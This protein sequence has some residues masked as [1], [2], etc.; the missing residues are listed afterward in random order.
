ML[1]KTVMLFAAAA[2]AATVSAEAKFGMVDMVLLVRNH[3]GYDANKELLSSTDKD[4]QKKLDAI[5]ADGEKLQ[6]EGRQLAEQLRNPMLADKAKADLEKQLIDLQQKLIGV[7]QRYRAEAMRCRQDLQDLEG[8]L[9]KTTT[10]DLKRRIAKFAEEK[11]YDLILDKSAA[12]FAK[13]SFE[14][15]DAVLITMGVDPKDAKGRD[16][17][18]K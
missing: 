2:A 18:G 10:D 17:E 6:A 8:R 11:E 1:K 14:V 3:P 9:L 16:D 7:E 12:P 4:F 5:K 15:T 13:P